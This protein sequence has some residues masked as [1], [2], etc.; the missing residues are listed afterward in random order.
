M[1]LNDI[2]DAIYERVARTRKKPQTDG[3]SWRRPV[4]PISQGD[5][6]ESQ[7]VMLNSHSTWKS[8]QE[9][10]AKRDV[11]ITTQYGTNEEHIVGA[12]MVA[13]MP[14][15]ARDAKDD[16]PLAMAHLTRDGRSNVVINDGKM[17]TGDLAEKIQEDLHYGN[18]YT[19]DQPEHLTDWQAV[20]QGL[21]ERAKH[22]MNGRKHFA[23]YQGK[24]L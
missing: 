23:F 6:Y 10:A 24:R 20:Y 18:V 21:L 15:D 14:A 3:I 22:R 8:L 4:Q 16:R 13:I 7:M 1:S 9:L 11:T 17:R 5:E 2:P 19:D 12:G